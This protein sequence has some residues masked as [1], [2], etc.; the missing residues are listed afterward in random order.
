MRKTNKIINNLIGE[1]GPSLS[2]LNMFKESLKHTEIQQTSLREIKCTIY[3]TY[4]ILTIAEKNRTEVRVIEKKTGQGF[5]YS[6]R[7]KSDKSRGDILIL[8]R[9]KSKYYLQS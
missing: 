2:R 1:K 3:Y 4:S 6:C 8:Q 9:E 5:P 7:V